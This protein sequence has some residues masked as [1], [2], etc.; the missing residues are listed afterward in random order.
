[1]TGAAKRAEAD[2]AAGRYE[3]QAEAHDAARGFAE[4][5][6]GGEVRDHRKDN[7]RIRNTDTVGKKGPVPPEGLKGRQQASALVGVVGGSDA[8]QKPAPVRGGAAVGDVDKTSSERGQWSRA[9]AAHKTC[10]HDQIEATNANARNS[11]MQDYRYVALRLGAVSGFVPSTDTQM[12]STCFCGALWG[13][14][15]VRLRSRLSPKSLTCRSEA[16][17]RLARRAASERSALLRTASFTECVHIEW[18]PNM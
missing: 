1:M 8:P 9:N 4:R 2:R 15:A 10:D 5:S 13:Y 14:A 7:N 3:T 17:S 6:G 11:N 12:P 18:P 16:H